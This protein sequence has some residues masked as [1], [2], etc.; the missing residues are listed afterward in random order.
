LDLVD[1]MNTF[2]VFFYDVLYTTH[3]VHTRFV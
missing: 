1:K 2:V 3:V